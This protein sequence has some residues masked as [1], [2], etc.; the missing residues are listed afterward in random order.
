[1][2]MTPEMHK[3]VIEFINTTTTEQHLFF[4]Q[5][6]ADKI[7]VDVETKKGVHTHTINEPHCN[8]FLNGMC[9]DIFIQ[10]EQIED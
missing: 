10:R 8:I 5:C 1:M 7:S 2:K 6:I 4:I 3:E 9:I